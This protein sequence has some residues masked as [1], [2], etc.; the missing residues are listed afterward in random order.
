MDK[1]PT[2]TITRA[3][4]H[5]AVTDPQRKLGGPQSGFPPPFIIGQDLAPYLIVGI[6]L[7]SNFTRVCT[8]ANGGPVAV[9]PHEY[10]SV[11]EDI[12]GFPH[13]EGVL[14]HSVKS[15]VAADYVV[16]DGTTSYT[17]ADLLEK[18]LSSVKAQ[19]EAN[20]ERLLSKA[21]ISVPACFTHR[22]RSSI[23][24]AADYA[25]VALLGLISDISASA[26][27]ACYQNELRNGKYL[28]V[29]SGTYSFETAVVHV[30]NRLIETKSVRGK[31]SLSG[32]AINLALVESLST[33]HEV[34]NVG[35]LLHAVDEAKKSLDN[36]GSVN[37][38]I[39]T[40]LVPLTRSDVAHSLQRHKEEMESLI[41]T[42]LSDSRLLADEIQGVILSGKATRSFILDNVLSDLF[43]QA[44]HYEGNVSAGAALQAALL[45]RQA[46]DWVIWDTT[47]NP[48]IVAQG[49][50]VRQVIGE[51]SPLP[52]SGHATLAPSEDGSI[53]ATIL[54]YLS[55]RDG[56][57]VQVAAVGIVEELPPGEGDSVNVDLTVLAT[58]D[59][60]L[61]FAARHKSL[62]VNLTVSVSSPPRDSSNVIT[63]EK[64][65]PPPSAIYWAGFWVDSL[66]GKWV[67]TRVEYNSPADKAG[68]CIYDELIGVAGAVIDADFDPNAVLFDSYC[69]K[70]QFGFISGSGSK[71]RTLKFIVEAPSADL[72]ELRLKVADATISGDGRSMVETLLGY[73]AAAALSEDQDDFTKS[74]S[75]I[76]VAAV[77]T[78][79]NC[80]GNR[81][82]LAVSL[83]RRVRW[84]VTSV[85]QDIARQTSPDAH[86]FTALLDTSKSLSDLCSE[87]DGLSARTALEL[88]EAANALSAII[89]LNRN[90]EEMRKQL[91]GHAV[92]VSA[93]NKTSDAAHLS[94]WQLYFQTDA[95]TEP[96]LPS[97]VA[98]R[99][100]DIVGLNI[101]YADCIEKLA[102]GQ[103]EYLERT[104]PELRE[105]IDAGILPSVES[106]ETEPV[107]KIML[108]K[109][110]GEWWL[111]QE[112]TNS[113]PDVST[114]SHLAAVYCTQG[115]ALCRGSV[116][117]FTIARA[118]LRRIIDEGTNANDVS[119]VEQ[120]YLL[121]ALSAGLGDDVGALAIAI[122]NRKA[123]HDAVQ[124][125]SIRAVCNMYNIS[126]RYRTLQDVCFRATAA[127]EHQLPES[128]YVYCEFMAQLGRAHFM[129][130][131]F[132][133]F[134]RAFTKVLKLAES[135][136]MDS[137]F[138]FAYAENYID[139]LFRMNAPDAESV[140]VKVRELGLRSKMIA[141]S[142][143]PAWEAK[144]RA[145]KGKQILH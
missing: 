143:C 136:E 79:Q 34:Q 124:I 75:A 35:A 26:L 96:L 83:S 43:P 99:E 87:R 19:V 58:S 141:Q 76:D 112:A 21:V 32:H 103:R 68:I 33:A 116:Q 125:Q 81:D 93:I 70:R 3:D 98:R 23:F 134:K 44:K 37:I 24:E 92:A 49:E 9:T 31:Q 12:I 135:R 95:G 14:V 126:H 47:P 59:G 48:V 66:N 145:N 22:Q 39:G 30:Q 80:K 138:V 5:P 110:Q 63:L 16:D 15:I 25:E 144:M 73:A 140:L 90:F 56:E 6:D 60:R 54:E 45:V 94:I 82:L 89:P 77:I 53:N 106:L 55:D 133:A 127:L 41:Q 78:E 142:D 13:A 123:S 71:S 131:D 118:L 100:I 11:V 7:G 20:T 117:A 69:T 17:P 115:V 29:S 4:E 67:V 137:Y 111:H 139:L 57:Y 113:E 64:K 28:V 107:S 91:L 10:S 18:L 108:Y 40:Q 97:T 62:D 132:P 38:R 2:F 129:M 72:N 119:H 130:G 114:L 109:K 105:Y 121:A 122:Y 128:F 65:D 52:I 88:V 8:Y 27:H 50:H 84:L 74:G 36:L 51:N 102:Q 86:V 101:R 1:E 85:L 61:D 104:L 42:T 46:K 120:R